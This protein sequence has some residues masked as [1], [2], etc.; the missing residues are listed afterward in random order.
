MNISF[1][2]LG[3]R[4]TLALAVIVASLVTAAP[5]SA[6]TGTKRM[7]VVLCNFQNQDFAPSGTDDYSRDY[8]RDM[9]SSQGAGK[10]GSYD[11]WRDIS[12]GDLTLD[13]TVVGWYTIPKQRDAWAGDLNRQRLW[14]ECVEQAKDDVHYEA[15]I[16]AWAIYPESITRTAAALGADDT[17]VTVDDVTD[18][19]A[20]PFS[21]QIFGRGTQ[22]WVV[23]S[24]V[25]E[26]TSTFTVQRGH[27]SSAPVAHANGSWFQARGADFFGFGPRDIE[28]AG[29]TYPDFGG[30]F[31]PH[32]I[33][34]TGALHETVHLVGLDHSTALS[35]LPSDY[36]DCHDVGSAFGCVYMFDHTIPLAGK[37]FGGTIFYPRYGKGPGL[38]SVNVDT[39]GWLPAERKT[40][41]DNS[42]CRQQTYTMTALNRPGIPGI[43][44][45]RFPGLPF[46][47]DYFAAELRHRSGWDRGIPASVFLLQAKHAD[48][49]SMLIDEN[50]DGTPIGDARGGPQTQ[51]V[52][53]LVAGD[54]YA[55][56]TLGMYVGVNSIGNGIGTITMASC[57][58]DVDL[59]YVGATQGRYT[60]TATL[61]G[62]LTVAGSSA[63]VPNAQV[64]LS[65]GG[66]SCT[67]ST[68]ATGLAECN[69]TLTPAPG[70][71]TATASY[72][73]TGFYQSTSDSAAFTVE[74]EATEI[75]YAGVGTSDYHDRFVAFAQLSEDDGPGIAG[76]NVTFTLGSGDGCTATTLTGGVASC[77]ITPTQPAATYTLTT[78]FGGDDRY[79][80]SSDSDAFGVTHEESTTTNTG[81]T[82]LLAASGSTATLKARFVEDGSNGDGTNRTAAPSG[83]TI[84]FSLGSE[85]C[86]ATTNVNGVAQCTV[87]VPPSL[88][89]GPQPVTASFAGDAYYEPS[90]DTDEAI[91]FAFPSTGAF[92]LGD[93]TVAAATPTSRVTWWSDAWWTA[94]S[95]SGG[96]APDSFKGFALEVSTLPSTNPANTCGTT[97]RSP[98]GNSPSPAPTAVP[99][100][101]GVIVASSAVKSKKGIGGQWAQVVVVRTDDGY[102]PNPGFKGTG[103]VV[104]TFCP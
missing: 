37:Q 78:S 48:G 10:W 70:S 98:P 76:R 39:M 12:Y 31:G 40:T 9:F 29:T 34:L 71:H 62:R 52:G 44:Q 54:G 68:D 28:L 15:F 65:V 45:L 79:E 85:T 41:F 74:R 97:F 51:G 72:A 69:V 42:S 87:A 91:V 16:G 101:M 43:Q 21:A 19:P 66:T 88:E 24:G 82:V 56:P 94:N 92:L 5:S 93:L 3:G 84:S 86:T 26:A 53:G 1:R 61:A 8:Y 4:V 100:Y 46:V 89:L 73:G 59:D 35:T 103:T 38:N 75:V 83:Q 104:A 17:T 58:I 95:L 27:L 60:D 80:A 81:P 67:A 6:L 30:A 36:N 11:Y 55:N 18:F 25:N 23:I 102:S 96:V 13:A 7:L 22:E 2:G 99:S 90:S 50:P 63:P 32:D 49:R 33:S 77:T 57:K 14:K 47:F 20:P 64:T